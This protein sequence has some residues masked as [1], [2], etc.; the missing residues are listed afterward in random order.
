MNLLLQNNANTNIQKLNALNINTYLLDGFE[1]LCDV[2]NGDNRVGETYHG[3]FFYVNI[4]QNLMF[5]PHRSWVYMI[6][7]NG[8]IEKVGET[9][10]PLGIR[11]SNHCKQPKWSTE[12]RIGRLAYMKCTTDGRIREELYD[13]CNLGHVSIYVKKCEQDIF[14]LN[15]AG[16]VRQVY[17]SYHKDLELA[18]LDYIFKETKSYPRLNQC[19]K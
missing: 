18:I 3:K 8:T 6:V 10:N 7:N 5:S 15:V 16:N 1:K 13:A 12:C 14:N 2:E 17:R 9:G 11:K 4:N 19:R